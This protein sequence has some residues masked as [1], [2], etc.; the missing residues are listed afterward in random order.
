MTR[1][2]KKSG[3]H[4]PHQAVRPQHCKPAQRTTQLSNYPFCTHL[5]CGISSCQTHPAVVHSTDVMEVGAAETIPFS[6][7]YIKF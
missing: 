3:Y 7:R 6:V 1:V 5:H 4:C 2:K